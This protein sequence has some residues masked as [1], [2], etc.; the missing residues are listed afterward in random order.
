VFDFHLHTGPRGPQHRRH[1]GRPGRRRRVHGGR[2]LRP[3]VAVFWR[4][5]VLTSATGFGFPFSRAPA[6]PHV[7][8]LSLAILPFAF[9]ALYVKHLA[10][11]W[12]QVFVLVS[13][14]ASTSTCSSC[15]AQ[16]LQKVRCLR[17]WRRRRPLRHSLPPQLL[18]LAI[19]VGLAGRRPR[20]PHRAVACRLAH[21]AAARAIAV[22]RR[23]RECVARRH[24]RSRIRDDRRGCQKIGH[25]LQGRM[26]IDDWRRATALSTSLSP[27][28]VR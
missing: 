28:P 11:P 20:L 17:P 7:G 21:R 27:W 12:R 26:G 18:F 19:F 10:G 2:S 15:W 25:P 8:A 5:R 14:L 22:T 13:V 6:L 9:V 1:R 16:L 3:R 4:P 24:A 23:R